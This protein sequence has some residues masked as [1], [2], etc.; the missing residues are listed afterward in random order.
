[1]S[2][3]DNASKILS[4]L[5]GRY[6]GPGGAAAII[7]KGHV[8]ATRHWGYASLERRIPFTS[9]TLFRICSIT[10]Q[11]TCALMLALYKDPEI[12]APL[13]A[14][15]FPNLV[16]KP[17]EVFPSVHHL[18]HNQSGLRDYWAVAMLQGAAIEG[19][20]NHH[21]ADRIFRET[22]S[23]QFA[24]GTSYSYVNQNFRLI[25]DALE[26][27]T[28]MAFSRLLERHIF[29]PAGMHSALLAAE[30][31]SLPDGSTGYEGDRER[32]FRPARNRTFWTGD[33]GIAASL[34]D[35]IAW[36]CFIDRTYHDPES[37]YR[38]ISRP[39]CFVD[40]TL[41]SYGFGLQHDIIAGGS[42][43]QHGGALRGWRSHRLHCAA[44]RLSIIVLFNHMS[45][46]HKAVEE[47]FTDF[48]ALQ[49]PE[50]GAGKVTTPGTGKAD[51]NHKA[52]NFDGVWLEEETGL[53]AR[54]KTINS[55]NPALE[56]R[57]LMLPEILVADFSATPPKAE[58]SATILT[59]IDE[60]HLA[61]SHPT[62]NRRSI[63]T[64]CPPLADPLLPDAT[65]FAGHYLCPELGGAECHITITGNMLYGGFSGLMGTGRMERLERIAPDLWLFPCPRA[66][67]HTAPG[68]WT[69][70]FERK[71]GKI[72]RLLVGCWLARHLAFIPATTPDLT[73]APLLGTRPLKSNH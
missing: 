62:E 64:R 2:S 5:A 12:L 65:D 59:W 48:M 3:T 51:T 36:E 34:E 4:R 30:T 67:D 32:G 37:L 55:K 63:L 28:G 19:R 42:V 69:L 58:N 71:K 15:R 60:N 24:P 23:L 20:F 1:M 35:M 46:A 39:V 57:Y 6:P 38:Q 72:S 70:V 33:A 68:D 53:S 40:G 61:M 25:S 22:Y 56:L 26:E 27:S 43:T 66:L 14:K 16:L 10:K 49:N 52:E 8:I 54:L 47:I 41:A 7:H 21:D 11:F 44:Q 73:T 29:Q 17:G 13:I 9:D 31:E 18:A 50:T 45:A